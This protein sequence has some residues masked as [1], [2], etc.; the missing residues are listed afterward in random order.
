M[1]IFF[2]TKAKVKELPPLHRDLVL[3]KRLG[4]MQ[5]HADWQALLGSLATHEQVTERKA[6]YALPQGFMDVAL[7]LLRVLLADSAPDRPVGLS[8]M[9]AVVGWGP[10]QAVGDV[11]HRRAV[12]ERFAFDVPLQAEAWL[13]DG[14]HLSVRQL[15]RTRHRSWRQR[16]RSGKTKFKSKSKSKFRPQVV[17]RL[18]KDVAPVRPN[19]PAPP[20]VSVDVK[21]GRRARV[22]VE[23]KA[24]QPA[25]REALF[26]LMTEA[27]RWSPRSGMT[28][29]A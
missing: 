29:A 28:E 7:P 3:E 4:V 10:D 15:R 18:P 6:K 23:F 1:A 2:R 12:K 20:S 21:P 5:S 16:S 8:Y 26:D 27:F 11:G 17:L 9:E 22:L 25:S 14:S 13:R 19:P 24:E